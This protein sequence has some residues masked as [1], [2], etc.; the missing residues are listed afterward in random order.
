MFEWGGGDILLSV[1]QKFLTGQNSDQMPY[2]IKKRSEIYT[3]VQ[4][5]EQIDQNAVK[6]LKF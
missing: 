3:E 1:S 6:L 2:W 5:F 4:N